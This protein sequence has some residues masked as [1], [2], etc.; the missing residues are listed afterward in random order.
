MDPAESRRMA[1]KGFSYFCEKPVQLP[2][3][4]PQQ[5]PS[6]ERQQPPRY[7]PHPPPSYQQ[8]RSSRRATSPTNQT[9]RFC[10]DRQ[11]MTMPLP[12]SRDAIFGQMIEALS[13]LMDRRG[14]PPLPESQGATAP[15]ARESRDDSAPE[16]SDDPVP[17]AACDP[18]DPASTMT[19]PPTLTLP[20][21]MTPPLPPDPAGH[22]PK[23]PCS[24]SA[25]PPGHPP[26][27]LSSLPRSPSTLPAQCPMP[28][29]LGR[30]GS[31]R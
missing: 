14:F 12:D 5:L 4:R 1:M 30:L 16:C 23:G 9:T 31:V 3:Y 8:P 22:L 2:S 7:W 20:V 6:Y 13:R 21:M 17:D 25:L 15:P 26:E 18:R 10:P 27:F 11:G 29:F 24:A 28:P 19:L